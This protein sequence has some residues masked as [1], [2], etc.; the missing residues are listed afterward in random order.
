VPDVDG[1]PAAGASEP[2]VPRKSPE[3]DPVPNAPSRE[4]LDARRHLIGSDGAIAAS[5][6]GSGF[7][8]SGPGERPGFRY[9]GGRGFIEFKM[10][11][12]QPSEPRIRDGH[13]TYRSGI[14]S[15][16]I[17]FEPGLVKETVWL[18]ERPPVSSLTWDVQTSFDLVLTESG[19]LSVRNDLGREL[20]HVPAP[21]VVD[22]AGR[23]GAASFVVE[24]GSVGISIDPGFL[25]GA[26]YPVA[27]DPSVVDPAASAG[28]V[29]TS[30]SRRVIRASD[31]RQGL[32]DGSGGALRLR[33]AVSPY[34]SWSVVSLVS[35]FVGDSASVVMGASNAAHVVYEGP[36]VGQVSY[37]PL[38]Y[39]SGWSKGSSQTLVSS[40]GHDPSIV[41]DPEGRLWLFYEHVVSGKL[42]YRLSSDGGNTWT[43][44]GQAASLGTGSQSGYSAPVVYLDRIGVAFNDRTGRL[45]WVSTPRSSVGWSSPTQL[46]SVVSSNFSVVAT[47]GGDVYVGYADPGNR[48]RLL[49]G[50]QWT[51][52]R[53]FDTDEGGLT[54]T[55]ELNQGPVLSTDGSNVSALYSLKIGDSQYQVRRTRL[56]DADVVPP[57]DMHP[58]ELVF[59]GV[60]DHQVAQDSWV[61][62]RSQA[63]SSA[64]NADVPFAHNT[65]DYLYVG[66]AYQPFG[67]VRAAMTFGARFRD[68]AYL[69]CGFDCPSVP[70]SGIR[71]VFEYWTGSTWA[72]VTAA[73]HGLTD[74]TY[75]FMYTGTITFTPP[76]NWVVRTVNN[77]QG[78]FLR[79]KRTAIHQVQTPKAYQ[80]T[81]V[82]NNTSLAALG[83]GSGLV[84][85]FWTSFH[86]PTN[87]V[88]LLSEQTDITPPSGTMQVNGG[89]EYT[90]SRSLTL[91][92]TC[93]D[94]SQCRYAATST[95][96]N[97]CAPG[98]VPSTTWDPAPSLYT[99][100]NEGPIEACTRLRDVAGN[101]SDSV[102]DSIVLDVSG[103]AIASFAATPNPF[104]PNGDGVKDQTHIS[105]VLTDA[106]NSIDWQLSIRHQSGDVVWTQQG[107]G[108]SVSSSWNGGD[109]DDGSYTLTLSATDLLGNVSERT[110]TLIVD[111]LAAMSGQQWGPNPFSPNGDGFHD[112][113]T[114]RT[115]LSEP[116]PWSATIRNRA[117]AVIRS[118]SGGGQAVSF[119][120]DGRN[121]AGQ[122]SAPGV[123]SLDVS[124]EDSAGNRVSIRRWTHLG[125]APIVTSITPQLATHSDD[126][127]IDGNGFIPV[128]DYGVLVG[129]RAAPVLEW[130]EQRIVARLPS[131]LTPG[132]AEVRVWSAEVASFPR[133]ITVAN[134][135]RLLD[136]SSIRQGVAH[137]RV[138]PGADPSAI[139][140][141]HSV[142]L[143][144]PAVFNPVD[145]I[146]AR[147]FVLSVAAG[148]EQ[149]KVEAL[150]SD[151]DVEW[152]S[153]VGTAYSLLARPNDLS[154]SQWNL[155]STNDADIDAPEAWD[156]SQGDSNR[157]IAIIDSGI[158]HSDLDGR[159]V[160]RRAYG[161]P[162]GFDGCGHGTAVA[163]I[164][165]AI[166]NNGQGLAGVAWNTRLR[167]YRVFDS[168]CNWTAGLTA[169]QAL[170][171][172]VSDGNDVINMSFGSKYRFQIEE[173]AITAGRRAGR[174]F[175]ASTGNSDT[176]TS[177]DPCH[178]NGVHL[179]CFPASYPGV[180][181]VSSTDANGAV[182]SWANRVNADVYAPGGNVPILLAGGNTGF[183]SGTSF[184]APHVAGVAL[185]SR[186]RGV[187]AGDTE[188][189]IVSWTDGGRLNAY[190][191]LTGYGPVPQPEGSIV[192]VRGTPEIWWVLDGGRFHFPNESVMDSWGAWGQVVSVYAHQIEH[193]P[194]LGKVGYRPGTIM[195]VAN[196]PLG[197]PTEYHAV[198]PAIAWTRGARRQ[199][200]GIDLSCLGYREEDHY[201][202]VSS[203]DLT[204]HPAGPP[205]VGC[206]AYPDGAVLASPPAIYWMA[207]GQKLHFPA[208]SVMSSWGAA[209]K[210]ISSPQADAQLSLSASGSAVGYKPGTLV[211]RPGGAVFHIGK[212]A[213]FLL[214]QR[215]WFPTEHDFGCYNRGWGAIL[216][217]E[218][219]V[220]V[221]RHP[222]G[223]N[224]ICN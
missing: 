14:Y 153:P 83:T 35:D 129:G 74:R 26:A 133:Q 73:S 125:S 61:D 55:S 188:A 43:G 78:Y 205:S 81:A 118:F 134:F 24:P 172:A 165:G 187:S 158:S 90:K 3:P 1:S 195:A 117:E 114:F 221:D 112:G 111:T 136:P 176:S 171:D 49:R 216:A 66:N 50:G 22:S 63:I 166:T 64:N 213:D 115:R 202:V 190:R 31:G 95:S 124:A 167:S 148:T 142:V 109:A 200:T 86:N 161:I 175:V 185:L 206:I 208:P 100:A 41:Y 203:L 159:V 12:V 198:T 214:G 27:V 21:E 77:R 180:L 34:T 102:V 101:W 191:A 122:P 84:P 156:V 11:D 196:H 119:R 47:S 6:A 13:V 16:H 87:A 174:V 18:S 189:R 4:Y 106:T 127:T 68:A 168:A 104:S 23:V 105:A 131:G 218:A 89:A 143:V 92:Q 178:E 9:E 98:T 17:L 19:A 212:G 219:A 215:R 151:Q 33:T 139:A 220:H 113:I 59:T 76:T 62:L 79:V 138:R 75:G 110:T 42:M 135:D 108:G 48:W 199:M 162:D 177:N 97:Y 154:S 107:S 54:P 38:S 210:E 201:V 181:G 65:G 45:R 186:A 145:D 204:A 58:G 53:L 93:S 8:P 140:A 39:S 91:N 44:P 5:A 51:T 211:L 149:A 46:G 146:L 121:D 67:L 132:T 10:R 56:S 52:E 192:Q 57:I 184:A 157:S 2:P 25:D 72:E 170:N 197:L 141:R 128:G 70:D 223:G 96:G 69:E 40:S 217:A 160:Q 207:A 209:G 94:G 120:W 60:F 32:L 155:D 30:N 37:F 88:R 103:P 116:M 85:H 164:A 144:G 28:V 173:D 194:I 163:G 126:I 20:L 7:S 222:V 36:S 183:G 224:L 179:P 169:T 182:S 123:Y 130:T 15:V 29:Q 82:G 71:P 137:I 150:A 99:W 80:V 147:W 152:A 193:L